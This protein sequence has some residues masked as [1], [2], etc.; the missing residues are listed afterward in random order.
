MFSIS[1]LPFAWKVEVLS[2]SDR[3]IYNLLKVTTHLH[4]LRLIS[5]SLTSRYRVRPLPLPLP[6]PQPVGR[7]LNP[8]P[9]LQTKLTAGRK[10]L[11]DTMEHQEESS[12]HDVKMSP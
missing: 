7:D 6:F 9:K 11:A 2:S 10:T 8:I 3:A 1:S 12:R 5:V 4:C